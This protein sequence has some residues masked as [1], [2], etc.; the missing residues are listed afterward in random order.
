MK[1]KV[2]EEEYLNDEYIDINCDFVRKDLNE[3]HEK[4][5]SFDYLLS[6][7]GKSVSKY[8]DRADYL[9]LNFGNFLKCYVKNHFDV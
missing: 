2:D 9:H 6:M 3:N 5:Y 1:N 7:V 8:V 4:E